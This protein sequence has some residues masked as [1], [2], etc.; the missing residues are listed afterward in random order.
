MI[1]T[2]R[3]TLRPPRDDDLDALHAIFSDPRAMRYWS[4]AAHADIDRT[5]KTLAGMIASDADTGLE[6]VIECDG[7]VIGKAGMWRMGEIGYILHPDRWGGGFATEA[8]GAVVAAA[9]A[10][11]P[12][13]DALTAEIDPRNTGSAALLA[14][15]G[16][17]EVERVENAVEIGGKWF[18]SG[19]WRLDRPSD[20]LE[21]APG[22]PPLPG[23]SAAG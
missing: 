10:R 5:R 7:A 19:F 6:F 2:A 9:F 4:H 23:P 3:L 14:R 13:L 20:P 15:L 18:D 11:H 22:A 16:F 1:R 12:D 21:N 17:R 8:V